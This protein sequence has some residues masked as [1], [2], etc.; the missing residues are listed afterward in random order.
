V[1][2]LAFPPGAAAPIVTNNITISAAPASPPRRDHI[3]VSSDSSDPLADFMCVDQFDIGGWAPHRLDP[4]CMDIE[5]LCIASTQQPMLFSPGPINL[6]PESCPMLLDAPPAPVPDK[7]P[8]SAEGAQAHDLLQG[9]FSAPP[10]SVLGTMPPSPRIARN[11]PPTASRRITRSS[12]K[13]AGTPVSQRATLRL[14]KE[15]AAIDPAEQSADKA[16]S[17]LLGRFSEPLSSTDIDGLA[18]LARVDRE[19]IVRAAS[20]AG[21]EG[22][23]TAAH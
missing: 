10:A 17:A 5:A 9:L 2:Q 1:P 14:A 13:M 4:M 22:A 15:L 18:L 12:I 7:L 16:A 6:V 8:P 11:D 23:A 3:P 20:I 21:S 19:A